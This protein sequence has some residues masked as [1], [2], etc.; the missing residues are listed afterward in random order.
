MKCA[1]GLLLLISLSMFG[2]ASGN[3]SGKKSN[4]SGAL[5]EKSSG[6]DKVKVYKA[7]GTLQCNQGARISLEEMQKQLPGINVFSK[8]NKHDG[9]M[10][11]QL[12]GTP[13]G[14]SNVYE[15]DRKDLDAAI[16]AGFKLWTGE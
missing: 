14:N 11:I 10:R 5:V 9:M 6:I 13:T 16:K 15:I 7:D 4:S 1:L 2:C 8:E 12:C 3:C